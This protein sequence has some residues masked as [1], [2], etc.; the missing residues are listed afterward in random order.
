[1]NWYK[2]L[3]TLQTVKK[4]KQITSFVTVLASGIS[5]L[6]TLIMA[7]FSSFGYEVEGVRLRAGGRTYFGTDDTWRLQGYT[8]YGFKD[9]KFKYGLSGKWM[10]DRKRIILSAGNRRD[11]EQIGRV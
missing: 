3:D 8:A 9:N 2:M 7:P 6:G 1:M 10:V 4:F 11:V 5:M